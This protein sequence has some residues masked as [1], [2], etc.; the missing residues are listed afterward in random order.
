MN[1]RKRLRVFLI[2]FGAILAVY[3]AFAG[4]VLYKRSRLPISAEERASRQFSKDRQIE[5]LLAGAA[6]ELG[7][8][9]TEQALIAYRKALSL[10]P[11]SMEA[12]LGVARSELLA[13][14]EQVAAQ[15][16]ERVLRLNQNNKTALLQLAGIHSHR[17]ETWSKSVSRYREYLALEPG[18]AGTQLRLA[19]VLAWQGKSGEAARIFSGNEVAKRMTFEDRRSYAL[20]LADSGQQARAEILIKDLLSRHPQ[21]YELQLQLA[22]I[23]AEHQDWDA[24]LPVYKELLKT[25]PGDPRIHLSY[26]MGLLS[27]RHDRDALGP[28]EKARRAMPSSGEAGLAYARALKG[29]GDLKKAAREFGRVLPKYERNAAIVREYADLLLEKRDYAKAEKYYKTAYGLRLRDE[30]LLAGLAGA[31][32]GNAKYKEALPYLEEAYRRQPTD[33]LAFELAKLYRRLGRY[34]QSLEL[35]S[36]LESSSVQTQK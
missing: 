6:Q 4:Y 31:L 24:A 35:L 12:Q 2:C 9:E 21:D 5:R 10:N 25:R 23:Y 8:G 3:Y 30:K 7:K 16:Y 15:E 14:R 1:L 19:R 26:G 33:R 32:S 34:G 22:S 36:K 28:L 18:D 29:A 11:S 13:G 20:V 17:A 27:M